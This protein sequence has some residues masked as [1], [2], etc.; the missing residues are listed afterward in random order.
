MGLNRIIRYFRRLQWRLT[1]SYT[2]VAVGALSMIVLILGYLLFSNVFIPIN[3]L[4]KELTPED[5]IQ[6]MIENQSSAVEYVLSQKPID[7]RLINLILQENPDLQISYF[8]LI[9]IGDFQVRVRTIGHGSG[10]LV[11]PD[12][13]LL[14]TTNPEFLPDEAVGKPL[15]LGILPGLEGPIQTALRGEIDP[16][17]LMVT[18][19]PNERFYFAVPYYDE[20]GQKVIAAGIIYIES[21]PTSEDVP[22]ITLML[23]RQSVLILLIAAALFGTIFGAFTSR[24][25]VKQLLRI[26]KVTDSWS[27]GDFSE[28][29]EDTG[30]DEI[31]QLAVRLNIMAEKLQNFLK[32][33][34]E[35]AVSE[36]RNRLARD[37]HDSAKQEALAAS[38]QL[39]TALE[40]FDRDPKNAKSHL[41]EADRLV[42][43]VRGELTDLIHE[44][45]PLSMNGSGFIETLNEYIIEWAH[46]IGIGT[47]FNVEGYQELPLEVKQAIYRI[48]QEALA[49]VARH[50]S[51][52]NVSVN[53]A[54]R[55]DSVLIAITDDGAGFDVNQQHNGIGLDSMRERAESFKGSFKIESVLD[56]GTLVEVTF[57]VA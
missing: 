20:S 33:S 2:T 50:S 12:L 34:Q 56:H 4:N 49:N 11:D 24:G 46:Q 31:S 45:R 9:Q 40:L 52:D 55:K 23:F 29:I 42:D 15:D 38:F 32:R 36:E 8:D 16:D 48:L 18:I 19:K 14:G 35:M 3:I 57:P 54:F 25:M 1:L 28:F 30:E 27:Q 39:G 26:S 7:T 51:A 47:T 13:I 10:F 37:L 41:L 17:R 21:L 5:W 43:S 6:S 44:L 53:L 22:A